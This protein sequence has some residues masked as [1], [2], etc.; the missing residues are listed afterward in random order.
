MITENHGYLRPFVPTLLEAR[1]SLLQISELRSVLYIYII[2][3]LRTVPVAYIGATTCD[4][5]LKK[6]T[7]PGV[8]SLK[9]ITLSLYELRQL[10][11]L[12]LTYLINFSPTVS[13]EIKKFK[14]R[15]QENRKPA[16]DKV[17]CTSS[18]CFRVA[19]WLS[20]VR[21][22]MWLESANSLGSQY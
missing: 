13:V 14:T 5:W 6:K 4:M 3:I 8:R 18:A 9:K 21:P 12:P 15:L 22:M 19:L 16:C 17:Q 20:E 11:P 10:L 2:S 1:G 7:K